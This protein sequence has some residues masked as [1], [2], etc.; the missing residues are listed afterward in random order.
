MFPTG[1]PGFALLLLRVAVAIVT[2]LVV[3]RPT[4]APPTW[5]LLIA[6]IISLGLCLGFLTPIVAALC[7]VVQLLCWAIVGEDPLLRVIALLVTVALALLG[8][9]AYS[10][11]A[12]RFGRQLVAFPRDHTPPHS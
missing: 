9:G 11:D 10:I 8:P 7:L 1:W 6:L 12:R 5:S 3:C 2:I 4:L